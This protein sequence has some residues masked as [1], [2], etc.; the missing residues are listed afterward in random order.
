VWDEFG[1][2]RTSTSSLSIMETRRANGLESRSLSSD[3]EVALW[4][5]LR[6]SSRYL[7]RRLHGVGLDLSG[8]MSP[9]LS[10]SG[11][12]SPEHDSLGHQ[13]SFFSR[14]SAA[15]VM[16]G[17]TRTAVDAVQRLT[18]ECDLARDIVSTTPVAHARPGSG[19]RRWRSARHGF[20]PIVT[21]PSSSDRRRRR[22]SRPAVSS[23]A[24]AVRSRAR[25]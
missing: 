10:R 8:R 17:G 25:G 20:V 6:I 14:Q 5:D 2:W 12:A 15:D 24:S 9:T 22:L 3:L 19:L 7:T 13:A 21:G 4:R 1:S 11:G 23:T 16:V 18:S